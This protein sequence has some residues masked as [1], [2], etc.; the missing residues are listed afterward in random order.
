[1]RPC[2]PKPNQRVAERNKIAEHIGRKKKK[3]II[4]VGLKKNFYI[5]TII[6]VFIIINL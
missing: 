1:M 5:C 6:I 3:L 2:S 4:F